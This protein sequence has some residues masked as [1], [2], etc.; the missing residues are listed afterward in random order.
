MLIE[1]SS[2]TRAKSFI[3]K[4]IFACFLQL[5]IQWHIPDRLMLSAEFLVDSLA[6]SVSDT[7]MKDDGW[8]LNNP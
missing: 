1:F 5:I 7:F 8:C 2:F 6:L 4:T 3:T